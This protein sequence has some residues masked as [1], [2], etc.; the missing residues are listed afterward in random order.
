MQ[1]DQTLF[2]NVSEHNDREYNIDIMTN[3]TDKTQ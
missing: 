2:W 3:S 1:I